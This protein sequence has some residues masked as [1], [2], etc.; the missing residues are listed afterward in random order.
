MIHAE[1]IQIPAKLEAAEE[2]I[3]TPEQSTHVQFGLPA[4]VSILAYCLHSCRSMSAFLS[5]IRVRLYTLC[6]PRHF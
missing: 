2:K 4:T 5:V 3:A 6:Q 1:V